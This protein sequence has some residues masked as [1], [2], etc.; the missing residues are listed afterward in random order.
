LH[1]LHVLTKLFIFPR[2]KKYLLANCSSFW[3]RSLFICFLLFPAQA[4]QI[5]I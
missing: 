2:D 3:I 1:F 4:Y 5:G